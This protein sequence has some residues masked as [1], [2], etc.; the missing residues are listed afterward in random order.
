V[1]YSIFTTLR[2]QVSNRPE[3]SQAKNAEHGRQ[4]QGNASL[5]QNSI[6]QGQ[7]LDG[8]VTGDFL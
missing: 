3:Q 1:P 8:T 4:N 5:R 6:N 7:V 2:R